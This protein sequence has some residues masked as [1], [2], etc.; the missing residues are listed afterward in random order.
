VSFFR[1]PSPSGGAERAKKGRTV[2]PGTFMMIKLYVELNARWNTPNKDFVSD[3][4][5][6]ETSNTYVEPISSTISD[7]SF[8]TNRNQ[9][10]SE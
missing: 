9:S 4:R 5:G 7:A 8:G 6:H 1:I 3:S 10:V 2:Q